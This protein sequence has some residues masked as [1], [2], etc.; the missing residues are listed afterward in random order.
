MWPDQAAAVVQTTLSPHLSRLESDD[1]IPWNEIRR[2]VSERSVAGSGYG[3]TLL[4]AFVKQGNQIAI[5][6]LLYKGADIDAVA[7]SDGYTPLHIAIASHDFPIITLLLANSADP[8]VL[9]RHE[10]TALGLAI[11]LGQVDTLG[12]ILA[13]EIEVNCLAR[14]G[15]TP[16]KP[17]MLAIECVKEAVV[18]LLLESGS[19]IEAVD[20][21][22]NTPLIKAV[23]DESRLQIAKQ[24]LKRGANI[25][26]KNN[27][28][29]T[30]LLVAVQSGSEKMVQLLLQRRPDIEARSKDGETALLIAAKGGFA[31]IAQALL[32]SGAECV[33]GYPQG[34]APQDVATQFPVLDA[35]HRARTK[36]KKWFQ[37]LSNDSMDEKYRSARLAAIYKVQFEREMQARREFRYVHDEENESES[38]EG[39]GGK[40][41]WGSSRRLRSA[42]LARAPSRLQ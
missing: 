35:L 21:N 8:L 19:Q 27:H 16:A 12:A 2:N 18:E 22:G 34:G 10:M 3:H 40:D 38:E 42:P 24:L 25:D 1:A 9:D 39:S 13:E 5:K 32:A 20:D 6:Y 23:G 28:G 30:P 29:V 14:G 41:V 4:H 15:A 17:L 11:S 31:A 37:K 36:K 26:A 7:N 33:A